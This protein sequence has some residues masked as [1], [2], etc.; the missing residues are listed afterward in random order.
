MAKAV[1]RV[2]G[3]QA[4][5]GSTPYVGL[6]TRL[7]GFRPQA[8]ERALLSGK[9]SRGL[10]MRGT[11]HVVSTR[12]YALFGAALDV[13]AP[14]WLTPDDEEI[15]APGRTVAARVHRGAAH[16][17]R[18]LRL[19]RARA[20]DRLRRHQP[21]LVC[22]AD[23][24][25]D[26]PLR[27]G[28]PLARSDPRPDLRRRRARRPR[29]S[30]RARGAR[31]PLPR[32]VRACHP[33]RDRRLVGPQGAR[34]RRPARRAR[35]PPRRPGPRA[36]RPAACATAGGRHARAGALPAEVRQR[37]ARPRA[38]PARGLPPARRPQ[39]RGR[40][41]DLH[42]RRLRRRRLARREEAGRGRA[43]RAASA[44]GQARARGRASRAW[45]PG[46]GSVAR[47]LLG[48]HCSGGI[49]KSLD[50]AHSFGMD[51]RAALRP[52]PARLALPR[53]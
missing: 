3:L 32:R 11:V 26:R 16:A 47:M 53:A 12:D 33:R 30:G 10:L 25:P 45:K 46:S 52:E 39:E 42:G 44:R 2:A 51:S 38:R 9:V 23:P 34:L 18:D 48:G 4:Q 37:A 19:A 5:L 27:R 15:A 21:R 36:A 14:A 17:R 1:E 8:L 41:A 6:W 35:R 43:V 7:E 49:K 40:A 50:N 29:R 28:E 31:A 20:R 24:R 13:A 22:D